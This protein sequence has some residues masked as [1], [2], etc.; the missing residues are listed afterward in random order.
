MNRNMRYSMEFRDR[1]KTWCERCAYNFRILLHLLLYICVAEIQKNVYFTYHMNGY[2]M[3]P[4]H[5]MLFTSIY[6]VNEIILSL[7]RIIATL[8]LRDSHLI[9][10]WNKSNAS[11]VYVLLP[12][13]RCL[14]ILHISTNTA[15]NI[16]DELLVFLHMTCTIHYYS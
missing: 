4:E 14:N 15:S 6:S 5:K 7:I 16:V 10:V 11:N 2:I 3:L 12:R 13:T 1:L 9:N 8:Q